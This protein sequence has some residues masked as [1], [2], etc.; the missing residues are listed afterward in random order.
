[1]IPIRTIQTLVDAATNMLD[2]E[3]KNIKYDYLLFGGRDDPLCN[4]NKWKTFHDKTQ[5][6]DKELV[7][8]EGLYHECINET[9]PH[10]KKV[11]KRISDWIS[12]RCQ[13]YEYDLN[14]DNDGDDEEDEE[15]EEEEEE[16][17]EHKENGGLLD[18]D[19]L[20]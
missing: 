7:V 15:E 4:A 17:D 5:S 20:S 18:I 3:S 16:E 2:V 11:I 10:Q 19:P 14:N 8:F 13:I 9:E 6:Y 1:M 12:Q